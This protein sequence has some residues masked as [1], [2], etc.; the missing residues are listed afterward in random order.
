MAFN[1]GA[2]RPH[3]G[4]DD[5][6]TK[7]RRLQDVYDDAACHEQL[8]TLYK[9]PRAD[10]SQLHVDVGKPKLPMVDPEAVAFQR[11]SQSYNNLQTTREEVNFVARDMTKP[12]D[13]NAYHVK[14]CADKASIDAM[15]N[16]LAHLC[17]KHNA[18]IAQFQVEFLPTQSS[19]G[20]ARRDRD[21][22]GKEALNR[23]GLEFDEHHPRPSSSDL[24]RSNTSLASRLPP[25][26]P[27]REQDPRG[28]RNGKVAENV[29]E[30]SDPKER[31]TE[32]RDSEEPEHNE[33][34]LD[35]SPKYLV[36]MT[37][38]DDDSASDY[39]AGY[40]TDGPN[41]PHADIAQEFR[42][43]PLRL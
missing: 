1:P 28:D 15:A 31:V 30:D 21:P 19:P 42:L 43:P 29:P 25:K 7:N 27:V 16:T 22:D 6:P 4:G 23:L 9:E 24:L 40:A 32:E 35:P 39:S 3:N 41:S 14:L 12:K 2:R 10:P 17:K 26:P 8:V 33:A 34:G 13:V 5:R 36:D 38:E 37:N 20:P 11:R 18:P